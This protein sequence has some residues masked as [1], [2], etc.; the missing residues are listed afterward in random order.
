MSVVKILGLYQ[1]IP[2]YKLKSLYL[3]LVIL[4]PFTPTFIYS[5]KESNTSSSITLLFFLFTYILI[6]VIIGNYLAKVG[7]KWK[8]NEYDKLNI[9]LVVLRFLFIQAI[10]A[11][12]V[13]LS[14]Y[15]IIK[16]NA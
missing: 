12:C 4:L 15:A 1:D 8:Q 2:Y 16:I 10:Y 7:K 3:I 14:F 11:I 9:E 13:F 5:R 6:T